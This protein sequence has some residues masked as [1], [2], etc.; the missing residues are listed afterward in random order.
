MNNKLYIIVVML[1]LPIWMGIASCMSLSS[2]S[3]EISIE[4]AEAVEAGFIVGSKLVSMDIINTGD[5][6]DILIGARTDFSNAIV[7]FHGI[8][9]G[10]MIRVRKI[11]IPHNSKIELKSGGSHIMIFGMPKN[12]KEGH[13]FVLYLIFRRSGEKRV[14]V[15]C[16]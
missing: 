4:K 14:T 10:R 15:K 12:I 5:G 13:E 6:D 7:E 1:F 9:D 8:D 11:H 16:T 3:P 2:G